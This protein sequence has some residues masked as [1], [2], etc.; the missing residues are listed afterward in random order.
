MISLRNNITN[1]REASDICVGVL[2]NNNQLFKTLELTLYVI[3]NL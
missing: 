1:F 3:N 2:K